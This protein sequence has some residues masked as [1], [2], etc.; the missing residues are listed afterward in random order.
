LLEMCSE[1]FVLCFHEKWNLET[2]RGRWMCNKFSHG[3]ASSAM[4]FVYLVM[5]LYVLRMAE[6][7]R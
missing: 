7:L 1:V 3:A 6:D 2:Y 4:D 5:Q